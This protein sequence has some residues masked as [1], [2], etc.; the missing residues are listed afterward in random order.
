M[1][2]RKPKK[3][4][5]KRPYHHGNL[6]D[7]LL[8]AG[9]RLIEEKGIQA[10]TLRE[11]GA[12]AGV[13]RM[14]LYRHF[15]DKAALLGAISEA[16]FLRFADKLDEARARSRD[17][18]SQLSAMALAYVRFAAEHRAHYEVMFGSA[19]EVSRPIRA[20]SEAARRAFGILQQTIREGQDA[21]AVR[22]GDSETIARYVWAQVHGI[23]SLRLEHDLSEGGAGARF[24]LFCADL[25]QSGLTPRSTPR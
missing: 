12:A 10:L 1:A 25:L 20:A 13:S 5:K 8:E 4:S 15:A 24:V 14:A 16:G 22:E 11:I 6:S 2:A 18:G 23:S 9:L 19:T 3:S 7:A 17:F 21:G